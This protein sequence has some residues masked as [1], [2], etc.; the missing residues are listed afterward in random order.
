MKLLMEQEQTARTEKKFSLWSADSCSK[1]R[2]VL[3]L[4]LLLLGVVIAVP[5]RAQ[6][7]DAHNE[8]RVTLFPYH[9]IKDQLPGIGYIVNKLLAIEFIYHAQFT[10]P[11]GSSHLEYTDNIFRL[12]FKID[13]SKGIINRLFYPDSDD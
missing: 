3:T 8:Y 11:T 10:R 7:D 1:Y 2:V 4:F 5:A 6:D 9:R 12:N 13:L